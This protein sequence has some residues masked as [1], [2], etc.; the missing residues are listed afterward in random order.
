VSC[1]VP[2]V[3]LESLGNEQSPAMN[4]RAACTRCC[5]VRATPLDL[6]GLRERKSPTGAWATPIVWFSGDR[7]PDVKI[8][9]GHK[10]PRCLDAPRVARRAK[11]A[12]GAL[13]VRQSNR[14]PEKFNKQI[15]R[16]PRRRC[17]DFS[18]LTGGTRR[19]PVIPFTC[20]RSPMSRSAI[21]IAE[22]WGMIRITYK[23]KNVKFS[24]CERHQ[25]LLC[26]RIFFVS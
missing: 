24:N 10:R 19:P 8:D 1:A 13:D 11:I 2:R 3:P 4:G 5:S 6:H 23:L 12:R 9:G 15:S 16:R 22:G 21:N 17:I 18:L 14:R 20:Q 25:W 7:P 26:H